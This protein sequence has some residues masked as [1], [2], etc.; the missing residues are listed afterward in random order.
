MGTTRAYFKYAIRRSP[1]SFAEVPT[2]LLCKA[3]SQELGFQV[4]QTECV[5]LHQNPLFCPETKKRHQLDNGYLERLREVRRQE[6]PVSTEH[7]DTTLV[8]H[9]RILLG[10]QQD[11]DDI[12]TAFVKIERNI[13]R[14]QKIT[15]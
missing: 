4:E 11:M 8:F 12:V 13:G 14:L 10:S 9:H 1:E 3:L 5:P 7:Y 6:F 2:H 15:G